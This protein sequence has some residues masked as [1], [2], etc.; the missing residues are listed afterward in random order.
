VKVMM[1]AIFSVLMLFAISITPVAAQPRVVGVNGG[2][3]FRWEDIEVNWSSNDPNATFPPPGQEWLAEMNDT[4]WSLFSIGDIVGT[5]VTCQFTAHYKNGT[6]EIMGGWVNID[7]GAGENMTSMVIGANLNANDSIYTAGY[8]SS[9]LI[10]ET[11]VRTY[12]DG[13][14]E[15]NHINMTYEYSWTINTTE[16]YY[17]SSMQFYWDRATGMLIEDAFESINQTGDYLTTWSAVSRI[18]ESNVWVI[19]EY[20][21]LIFPVFMTATLLAAI[22]YKRKI[23]SY[24]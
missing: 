1:R 15:T 17:F 13:L 22:I 24:A 16:Y 2:D 23:R 21:L 8:Y 11:V 19:P 9:W 14:R 18:S 10:N 12:P 7:T 3:W 20:P 6:E 4:E 5:N